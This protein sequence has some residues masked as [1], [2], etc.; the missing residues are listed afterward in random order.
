MMSMDNH[1]KNNFREER[2]HKINNE[3]RSPKILL[4]DENDEKQGIVFIKDALS[5]AFSLNLDLVE[6]SSTSQPPVCKIM[7]Y[8]KFVYH[9]KKKQKH[10]E[11]QNRPDDH[12][13]RISPSIADH[14]LKIKAKK[15]R[16]FIS[17]NSKVRILIK[18]VGRERYIPNIIHDTAKR[19]GD[20]VSDCAKMENVGGQYILVPSKHS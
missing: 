10:N 2:E 11:S 15:V 14:D 17:D 3:I 9:L 12:D 20:I 16:E 19:L 8:K 7:D 18:L 5:R 1:N 13:I 6:V 4:I